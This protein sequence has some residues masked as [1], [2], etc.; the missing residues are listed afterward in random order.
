MSLSFEQ[1][2]YLAV[3][4]SELVVEKTRTACE[5]LTAHVK[6]VAAPI[7]ET[8]ADM[9]HSAREV[10][11]AKFSNIKIEI[12]NRFDRLVTFLFKDRVTIDD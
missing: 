1:I 12:G 8:I 5:T 3:G 7:L 6:T 2:K 10:V 9:F 4:M 11:G